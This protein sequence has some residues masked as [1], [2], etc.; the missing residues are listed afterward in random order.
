MTLDVSAM[1]GPKWGHRFVI[2]VRPIVEDSSLLFYGA[3]LAS[4]WERY[5]AGGIDLDHRLRR[6]R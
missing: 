3:R 6:R 5:C 2:A 1:S 4:L